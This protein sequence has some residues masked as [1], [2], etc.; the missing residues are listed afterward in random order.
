MTSLKICGLRPGDDLTFTA[1]RMVSHVGFVFVPESKRYVKPDEACAMRMQM[2]PTS[3]GVGVFVD[4]PHDQVVAIANR[5]CVTVAQLH[6]HESPTFCLRIRDT[7]LKVWKAIR[8][9]PTA[10]DL[11]PLIHDLCRYAP[12]V[13]A[14][15]L[16]AAPPKEA[17]YTVS[18]G[19]GNVFD[20]NILPTLLRQ[21]SRQTN[22]PPIWVAGGIH[23]QNVQALLDVY[24]PFG[25]DVSSGVEE[26]SR[27][28]PRKIQQ[29]MEVL[30]SHGKTTVSG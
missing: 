19:H 7:G 29:M 18:G 15:L 25:I 12:V 30:N 24:V 28:S 5:A 23:P 1:S 11:Q 9:P 22:L 6:G 21:A 8:V 2:H 10:D 14:I 3:E 17:H 26:A 13:D 27:K 20:W 16:D 4:A